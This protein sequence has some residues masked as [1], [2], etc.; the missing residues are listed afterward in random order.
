VAKTTAAIR[1]KDTVVAGIANRPASRLTH[2]KEALD[3]I[4]SKEDKR[5]T[6]L[7]RKRKKERWLFLPGATFRC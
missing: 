1:E 4:D 6:L 5:E 2:V 3:A 7:I